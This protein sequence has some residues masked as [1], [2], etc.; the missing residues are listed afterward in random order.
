MLTR[1]EEASRAFAKE[2]QLEVEW[3]RIW[4]IEPILFDEA[5]IELADE[6]IREVAGHVAPAPVGPAPRRRRGLRGRACRP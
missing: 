1:A 6:A 4:R 3:E 5:L 2:E